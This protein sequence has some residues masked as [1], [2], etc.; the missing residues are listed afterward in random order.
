MIHDERSEECIIHEPIVKHDL[1]DL[2]HGSSI[3]SR[4]NSN[5]H[6]THLVVFLIGFMINGIQN[7]R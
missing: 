1:T 6:P 7:Y 5:L 4:N 2:I 3:I